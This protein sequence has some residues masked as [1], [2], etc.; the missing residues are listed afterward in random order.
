MGAALAA[1][2]D[3]VLTAVVNGLAEQ[4]TVSDVMKIAHSQ[5]HQV[6]EDDIKALVGKGDT[7]EALLHE[8]NQKRAGQ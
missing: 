6:T 4:I 7:L 8:V 1:I 3:I 2:A 5:G